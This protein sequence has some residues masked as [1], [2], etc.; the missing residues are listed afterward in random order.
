MHYKATS[1][2]HSTWLR[3]IVA[4]LLGILATTSGCK[5][6]YVLESA[7]YQAELLAGR[8][9]LER[10]MASADLTPEQR[11]R[12]GMIPEIK[13]W[14]E[15]NGLKKSHSYESANLGWKRT[16]YNFSACP[17]LSFEPVTWWFPVVG[18][19]PY[20]GFFRESK[21]L[22]YQE[23]YQAKGYDVWVRTA[24]AYSTLGW[25]RDPVLPDMLNWND[26]QIA[27]TILHEL[28]HA[29]LWLPGSVQLNETFANVV[30]AAA[31]E[32]WLIQRYGQGSPELQTMYERRS[33][34][35]AFRAILKNTCDKLN[36]LYT[37]PDI[38]TSEKLE[39]KQIIIESIED[40]TRQSGLHREAA[41]LEMVR[42]GPWNNAR[43]M[44]FRTYNSNRDVFE[45]LLEQE[46]GDISRFIARIDEITR[47][48]GDPMGSL[49]EAAGVATQN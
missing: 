19:V 29:T 22:R 18:R 40:S 48:S 8:Q 33:D 11:S 5:V 23:R 32:G 37:D 9:S 47:G 26:Y 25:F 24:G 2:L 41:Y 46:G 39:M 49:L 44:Q 27:E 17:P 4:P 38:P 30:G 3:A 14:G 15:Q 10:V 42:R 36:T 1:H 31:A 16:I 12:L 43:L 28:A 45:L 21:A 35:R 7:Y 20:L 13:A 6:G 34:S